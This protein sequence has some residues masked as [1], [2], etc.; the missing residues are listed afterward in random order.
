MVL[1]P[2]PDRQDRSP[3]AERLGAAQAAPPR[4]T[5]DTLKNGL[6]IG[7]LVGAVTLAAVGG[8]I[9]HLEQEPGAGN[10]L[11]DTLRVAAIGAG[12]GA[13]VGLTVDAALTRQAGIRVRWG[14]T[15]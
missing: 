9:C 3:I 12:I 5:P 6:I 7:A 1:A 8:L 4:S 2:A 11:S 14:V 10:C 15:F 13:G